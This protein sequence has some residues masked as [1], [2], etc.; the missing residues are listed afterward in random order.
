MLRK[1]CQA[2]LYYF[3]D[4]DKALLVQYTSWLF[5][6]SSILCL[7]ESH[8]KIFSPSLLLYLNII[9]LT[10]RIPKAVLRL[11]GKVNKDNACICPINKTQGIVNTSQSS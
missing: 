6:G 5:C 4:K 2:F 7:A 8:R 11:P 1:V 10:Y 3:L 9:N